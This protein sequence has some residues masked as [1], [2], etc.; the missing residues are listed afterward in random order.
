[1]I[2]DGENTFV[3]EQ[4]TQGVITGRFE[5]DG[6]LERRRAFVLLDEDVPLPTLTDA[7]RAFAR[8]AQIAGF[9][10][11]ALSFVKDAESVRSVRQWLDSTLRWRPQLMA[12][13]E[14]SAGVRNAGEIAA[15]SDAV[16][17]G[18]RRPRPARWTERAVGRPSQNTG[19]L[20]PSGTV[21]GGRHRVPREHHFDWQLP[22]SRRGYRRHG[23]ARDGCRRA[24]VVG[25]DDHR[26]GPGGCGSRPSATSRW[27]TPALQCAFVRGV[28]SAATWRETTG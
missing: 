18:R 11:L 15:E 8:A 13:I 2:G 9:D 17:I 6:I 28:P 3:V 24:D 21:R 20:S 4:S 27:A 19:R 12:K 7:D 14:T 16:L 22:D 26:S 25:R 10:W 1:M 5:R 23:C